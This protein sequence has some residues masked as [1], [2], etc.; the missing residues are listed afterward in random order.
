MADICS[1]DT[2]QP[3]YLLVTAT[4]VKVGRT[5]SL[6]KL[7]IYVKHDKRGG[8]DEH[9]NS[10][11]TLQLF[12]DV[13]RYMSINTFAVNSGTHSYTHYVLNKSAVLNSTSISI[14]I[15]SLT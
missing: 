12:F 15:H 4:R 14:Q 11:L 1:S 10:T 8:L 7:T 2:L 9:K 13:Q 5:N 6:S 3:Q